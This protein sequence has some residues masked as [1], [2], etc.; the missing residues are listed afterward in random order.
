MRGLAAVALATWTLCAVP[1]WAEHC[2]E[3]ADILPAEAIYLEAGWTFSRSGE[4]REHALGQVFTRV[5]VGGGIELRASL[6]SYQWSRSGTERSE[7]LTDAGA[8]VKVRLL[9]A[10][11]NIPPRPSVALVVSAAA[12]TGASS[13]RASHVQPETRLCLGWTLAPTLA[14]TSN[15]GVARVC[16][17]GFMETEASGSL[18]VTRNWS[19]G[20]ASYIEYATHAVLGGGG[21]PEHEAIAGMLLAVPG[22]HVELR[23]GATPVSRPTAWF[24]GLILQRQWN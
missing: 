15:L 12:P 6:N 16:G 10:R 7:G 20:L 17:G 14:A 8:G 19:L 21:S 2:T 13:F 1:A 5:G 9:G 11:P 23:V 3:G 24:G 4:N 18:S 22:A